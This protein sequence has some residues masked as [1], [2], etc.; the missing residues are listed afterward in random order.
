MQRVGVWWISSGRMRRWRISA[1]RRVLIPARKR[2]RVSPVALEAGLED[3]L[4]VGFGGG[5]ASR[6]LGWRW[7]GVDILRR[8][9]VLSV[10]DLLGV[11][12]YSTHDSERLGA[13]LIDGI[14]SSGPD[15]HEDVRSGGLAGWTFALVRFGVLGDFGVS[16]FVASALGV[17]SLFSREGV[18]AITQDSPRAGRSIVGFVDMART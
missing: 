3:G 11:R 4:E 15:T 14:I 12:T 2:V 10:P 18:E 8:L 9:R 16:D 7:L 13:S 17:V 6:S 1:I 5:L